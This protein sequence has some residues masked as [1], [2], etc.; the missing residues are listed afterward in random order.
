[1]QRAGRIGASGTGGMRGG[2]CVGAHT[3]VVCGR[4]DSRGR[5]GPASW[6]ARTQCRGYGEGKVHGTFK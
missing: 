4:R 1:M 2:G 3:K 6:A 5:L